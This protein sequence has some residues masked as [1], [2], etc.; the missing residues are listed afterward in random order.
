LR[1]APVRDDLLPIIDDAELRRQIAR[2]I[3]CMAIFY[4]RHGGLSL[5]LDARSASVGE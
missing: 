2:F 1:I 4:R 3:K 5:S